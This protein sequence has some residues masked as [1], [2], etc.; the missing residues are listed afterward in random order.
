MT[1]DS[2][3]S[4]NDTADIDAMWAEQEAAAERRGVTMPTRSLSPNC[5]PWCTTRHRAGDLDFDLDADHAL[6]R[7]HSW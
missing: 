7:Y 3:T 1:T 5:P 4:D 2:R 6:I